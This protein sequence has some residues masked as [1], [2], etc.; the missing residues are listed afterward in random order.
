M[1]HKKDW[2]DLNRAISDASLYKAPL[3]KLRRY[4]LAADEH[5]VSHLAQSIQNLISQ[6]QD[7]RHRGWIFVLLAVIAIVVALA[8]A[9]LQ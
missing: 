7:E 4:R 5:Y 6:R 3:G 9:S 2:D 1:A 8:I